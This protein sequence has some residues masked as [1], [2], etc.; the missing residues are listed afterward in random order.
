MCAA[1]LGLCCSPILPRLVDD[2]RILGYQKNVK[3]VVREYVGF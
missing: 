1:V 2:S 3:S